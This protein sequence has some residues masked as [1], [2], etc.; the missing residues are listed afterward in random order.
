MG[1]D[2]QR[3]ADRTGS[4]QDTQCTG[5]V[6]VGVIGSE[7]EQGTVDDVREKGVPRRGDDVPL[8][9]FSARISGQ[10]PLPRTTSSRR[11]CWSAL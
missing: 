3:V 10:G 11:A 2:G 9:K 1:R 7:V 6:E 4:A 5:A 8:L